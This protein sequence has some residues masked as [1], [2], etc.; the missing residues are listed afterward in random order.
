M[1]KNVIK[2]IIFDLGGVLLD[3][4]FQASIDAFRQLGYTR[5]D[6]SYAGFQRNEL[7]RAFETGRMGVDGFRKHVRSEI[8]KELSVQE[9]DQAW[10]R[11]LK[12]FPQEKVDLV[13]E[14][15]R[16]GP[17]Y[18]FSNT[19]PIHSDYFNKRMI[20]ENGVPGGLPAIFD[21]IFYSHLIGAAKPDREAY[22]H[23]TKQVVANEEECLFI[24]DSQANIEGANVHTKWHTQH[25]IIGEDL[26]EVINKKA[27]GLIS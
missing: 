15:R 13:Q 21:K 26:R 8:G 16:Y 10:C 23:V 5:F 3:L 25:Y 9:I 19:N 24:D 2:A 12:S 6:D 18:L 11:M 20:N 27:A 22:R 1:K 14:C 4:D 7:F 17:V